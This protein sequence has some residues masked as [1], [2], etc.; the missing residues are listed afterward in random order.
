MVQKNIKI[1][2]N[3]HLKERFLLQFKKSPCL[4]L[5]ICIIDVDIIWEFPRPR[6]KFFS[7]FD[8]PKYQIWDFS[9]N[10]ATRDRKIRSKLLILQP[11]DRYSVLSGNLARKSPNLNK[12]IPKY[13][14]CF[15]G[16]TKYLRSI[17]L[18]AVRNIFFVQNDFICRSIRIKKP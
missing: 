1:F 5:C 13:F 2:S 14:Y 8:T 9:P 11:A 17:Y 15:L 3:N 16:L 10:L 12:N 4:I 6:V 7:Q 18:F